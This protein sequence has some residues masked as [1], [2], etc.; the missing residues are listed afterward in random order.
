MQFAADCVEDGRCK[1]CSERLLWAALKPSEG[2]WGGWT[3]FSHD[4][5]PNL[6]ANMVES[7][8]EEMED[9]NTAE[10]LYSSACAC[11]KSKSASAAAIATMRLYLM[12]SRMTTKDSCPTLSLGVM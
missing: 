11:P 9:W 7:L 12:A 4:Q 2:L 3:S 10:R 1:T 6:A 5:D 8:T